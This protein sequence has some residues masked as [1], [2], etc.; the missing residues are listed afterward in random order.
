MVEK[1]FLVLLLLTTVV[2][3]CVYCSAYGMKCRLHQK[4]RVEMCSVNERAR[5]GD[6]YQQ[7]ANILLQY[8]QKDKRVGR[9]SPRKGGRFR[10]LELLW[11]N[12]A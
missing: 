1:S 10:E 3:N 12:G 8:N 9:L 2:M 11:P 5:T 7:Q 6:G 4:P